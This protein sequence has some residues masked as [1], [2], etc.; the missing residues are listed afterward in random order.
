MP[1]LVTYHL[2]SPVFRSGPDRLVE[3]SKR[4]E[5]HCDWLQCHGGNTAVPSGVRA[6]EWCDGVQYPQNGQFHTIFQVPLQKQSMNNRQ[7]ERRI[8][9]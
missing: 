1:H 7:T 6:Y 5:N 2:P 4:F 8:S 3:C 9:G